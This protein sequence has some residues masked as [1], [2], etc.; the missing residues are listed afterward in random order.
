MTSHLLPSAV[1]QVLDAGAARGDVT[2][3][4]RDGRP[5]SKLQGLDLTEEHQRNTPSPK[6]R[7]MRKIPHAVSPTISRKSW[8]SRGFEPPW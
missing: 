2:A 1:A 6:R 3:D 4:R 7:K 5:L 8:D